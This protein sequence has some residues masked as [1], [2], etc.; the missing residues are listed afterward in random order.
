MLQRALRPF[1]SKPLIAVIGTTGTGKSQLAVEL[2]L[3]IAK[4]SVNH[5]KDDIRWSG[6]EIIN[7]DAMQVY[8]GLD[9]VTNKVTKEE[10]KGVPHHLIGV[11]HPG[12]E[13]YVTEWIKDATTIVRGARK[14]W[15][16]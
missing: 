7:A 8:K 9:V 13:Y 14:L 3:A 4:N 2:S 12:E 1:N 10:M 5:G 6:G 11:R 16:I 15:Q